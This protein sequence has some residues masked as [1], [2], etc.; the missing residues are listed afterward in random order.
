MQLDPFTGGLTVW[1][2]TQAPHAMRG[3]LAEATGLPENQIRVIAPEVGGGFGAKIGAYPEDCPAGDAG[4]A[5]CKRPVKWVET[6]S[7][8]L[9]AMTHGRAQ[10]AD[11]EVAA[12]RDGT[13]TG[14][15]AARAG[16]P[17]RLPEGAVDADA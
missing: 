2:S 4:A 12:K 9:V 16:R 5:T 14:A 17:R 7:E 10:V 8:N 15:A 6:R 3:Q 11:I 13:V 1:C